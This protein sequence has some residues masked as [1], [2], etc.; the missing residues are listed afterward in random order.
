MHRFPHYVSGDSPIHMARP[1]MAD[2]S[3]GNQEREDNTEEDSLVHL[4]QSAM[5]T[6]VQVCLFN[7]D[8]ILSCFK[9]S[10]DL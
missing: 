2:R 3:G 4:D 7:S 6:K 1:V 5:M 10:F 8:G 9:S